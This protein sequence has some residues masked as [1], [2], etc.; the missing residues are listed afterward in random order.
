[1]SI[2]PNGKMIE[3]FKPC[4][5]EKGVDTF[6]SLKPNDAWIRCFWSDYSK[7]GM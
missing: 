5:K 7:L 2:N 1:M 6:D 3:C 4:K